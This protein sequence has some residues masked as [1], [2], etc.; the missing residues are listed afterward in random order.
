VGCRVASW[1][2][3][4]GEDLSPPAERALPLRAAVPGH[5]SPEK[6][7]DRSPVPAVRRTV[8]YLRSSP[9]VPDHASRTP[10]WCF[11][12]RCWGPL[13]TARKGDC[14][15]GMILRLHDRSGERA[16]SGSWPL[17][18]IARSGFAAAARMTFAF[19]LAASCCST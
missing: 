10:T 13:R 17:G 4:D 1:G 9:S 6:S 7:E 11:P 8:A 15:N 14:H 3:T 18:R 19:F 5:S 16:A 2:P 12:G